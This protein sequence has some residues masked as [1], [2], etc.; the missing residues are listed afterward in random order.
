MTC[1]G[2]GMHG[3]IVKFGFL[4]AGKL[5]HHE[6]QG[7][8]ILTGIA[9]GDGI[10]I[11]LDS[12]QCGFDLVGRFKGFGSLLGEENGA[13]CKACIG[14]S[15]SFRDKAFLVAQTNMLIEATGIENHCGPIL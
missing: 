4:V 10:S 11:A 12:D 5:V 6:P 7:A 13:G 2:P 9:I 14:H 1:L 15:A 3:A 8:G